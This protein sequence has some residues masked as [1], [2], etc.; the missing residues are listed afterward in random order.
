[1]ILAVVAS[2]NK[3]FAQFPASL[4]TQSSRQEI[5]AAVEPMMLERLELWRNTNGR[6][7]D[8]IIIYRDG[9]SESQY[10]EVI[11]KEFASIKVAYQKC[12]TNMRWPRTAIIVVGKR[13]HTR[14]YPTSEKFKVQNG[15]PV[16]GTVVD[17]GITMDRGWDFFLQ[18]HDCIKG[19]A[20]TAHYVVILNEFGK[21]LDADKLEQIVS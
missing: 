17:R 2:K 7:P 6:Y 19:T 11:A 9:V 3:Y 12:Y 8:Q 14:F 5:V 16:S 21:D 1:M 13:H 10:Q 20:R 4:R 15:N 18:A